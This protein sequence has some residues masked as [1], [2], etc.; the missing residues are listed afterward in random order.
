M[1]VA[2]RW[3]FSTDSAETAVPQVS[4][5]RPINP[6]VAASAPPSDERRVQTSLDL[7]MQELERA[8]DMKRK[9]RVRVAE[10]SCSEVIRAA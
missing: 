10:L 1:D 6:T 9:H 2:T 8:L 3:N 7:A 4:V 5:A